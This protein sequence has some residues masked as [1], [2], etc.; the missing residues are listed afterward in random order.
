MISVF[1]KKEDR[2]QRIDKIDRRTINKRKRKSCI[3]KTRQGFIKNAIY[4]T[5]LSFTG[6]Y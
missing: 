5:R 4:G 2:I 1:N 6:I 3:S